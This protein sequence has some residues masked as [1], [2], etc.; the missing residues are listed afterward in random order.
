VK[1]KAIL[2]VFDDLVVEVV[3]GLSQL[4]DWGHSGARPDQYNHDVVADKIM[5]DGLVKAGFRVL[6]EE[7]GMTGDGSIL[8]VVDP[9][10]GSTNAARALPWYATS[11]CA[12]DDEGPLV[13]DVVNLANGDR[14]RAVRGRGAEAEHIDL[15]PSACEQLSESFLA[16]N[17]LPPEHGGWAQFRAYGA[18]ALELCAVAAGVFDGFVDVSRSLRVWDYLGACLVCSEMGVPVVDGL[19]RELEVYR[20]EA[21]A[22][23]A[24]A[25][26][27]LLE[28][29]LAMQAS[30]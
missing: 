22:P 21:R 3:D 18:A 24:A 1:P 25:T 9:I 19:G 6:S 23:V 12:V 4:T 30:W 26:P 10:D 11:L 14:Y 15:G 28:Q 5:L 17:G 7:S 8:V 29:M 16:L 2:D 13:A 20:P 27:A